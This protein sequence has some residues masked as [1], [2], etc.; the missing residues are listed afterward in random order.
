M[1]VQDALGERPG[2]EEILAEEMGVSE[3]S[4]LEKVVRCRYSEHR[5]CAAAVQDAS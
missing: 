5:R 1:V 4:K 2:V 3:G